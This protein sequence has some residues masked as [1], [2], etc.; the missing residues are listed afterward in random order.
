MFYLTKHPSISVWEVDS[1]EQFESG[2]QSEWQSNCNAYTQTTT[3]MITQTNTES[4]SIQTTEPSSP[5]H[6][7][8]DQ[9]NTTQSSSQHNTTS[10]DAQNTET[11]ATP[12]Q[13]QTTPTTTPTSTEPETVCGDADSNNKV[14]GTIK[15][16]KLPIPFIFEQS[17][18]S[19]FREKIHEGIKKIE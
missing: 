15:F 18:S 2:I 19:I 11:T 17:A 12:S 5:H 7:T 3:E 4:I 14:D 10:T 1:W 9:S 13:S 16:W 6:N 8:G